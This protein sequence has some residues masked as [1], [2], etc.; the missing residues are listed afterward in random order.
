M[1]GLLVGWVGHWPYIVSSRPTWIF[2]SLVLFL[3]LIPLVILVFLPRGKVFER[4]LK[5]AI[6]KQQITPELREALAD[7][8]VRAA[9][10]YESAA[11]S[12]ILALMVL[13][14]F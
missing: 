14:P 4:A 11:V 9:S 8:A 7:P 13:K 12:V 3:S 5:G 6:A 10:V 2:I 1:T